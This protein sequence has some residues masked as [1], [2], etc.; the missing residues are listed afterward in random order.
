[1][2]F[3][4]NAHE[5]NGTPEVRRTPTPS[6]LETEHLPVKLDGAIHVTNMD[7]YVPDAA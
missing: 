1:V 5:A 6:Y 7:T 3:I 4:A 2:V